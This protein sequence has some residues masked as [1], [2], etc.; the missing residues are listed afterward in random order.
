[1]SCLFYPCLVCAETLTVSLLA[2]SF[3]AGGSPQLSICSDTA[4]FSPSEE[5]HF[6]IVFSLSSMDPCALQ[7]EKQTSSIGYSIAKNDSYPILLYGVT[8]VIF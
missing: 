8:I 3:M 2:D 5:S 4:E 1:M 6:F 7:H